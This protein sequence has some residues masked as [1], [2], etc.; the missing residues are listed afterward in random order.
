MGEQPSP[1]NSAEFLRLAL[2]LM[3]RHGVPVTPQNYAVWF[4]YVAGT[5]QELVAEIDRLIAAG[6]PFGGEVCEQLYERH[7]AGFDVQQLEKVRGEMASILREVGESIAD[8][9]RNVSHYNGKLQSISDDVE[10]Q[11]DIKDVKALLQTLVNETR[12]MQAATK[13]LKTHF[14]AKSAEIASLREELERERRRAVTDALTGLPNRQALFDAIDCALNDSESARPPCIM[15]VDI[16]RF[17]RIND[18]YGHLIG[19][20]VIRFVASVLTKHTKGADTAAR[21]GGEEFAVL[22]PET[23]LQGALAVA[24][25]LRKTVADAKLVRSDTKEPLGQ[26]TIS[27]G[28][29]SYRPGEDVMDFVNRADRAL[30]ASKDR[31]RNRVTTETELAASAAS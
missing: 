29:A 9:G 31:G 8:A 27:L 5:N 10:R 11:Q 13:E 4:D 20:R 22:L 6:D 17:K 25:T 16:D 1:V 12:S 19:D 23:H 15:M 3:S 7:V 26:V 24:E 14:D 28:I 18:Q 2:P 21:Y 30:Y